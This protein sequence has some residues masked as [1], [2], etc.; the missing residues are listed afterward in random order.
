MKSKRILVSITLVFVLILGFSNLQAAIAEEIISLNSA[1][2]E[3]LMAIEDID[4]PE[5]LAK[6]IVEFRNKNL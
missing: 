4:I 5:N 2:V 3:Q 1:S 6:A